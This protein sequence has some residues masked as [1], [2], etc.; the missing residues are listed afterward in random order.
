MYFLNRIR[1]LLVRNISW[2]D[3]L[4]C[5]HSWSPSSWVWKWAL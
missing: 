2:S 3:I 1:W 4:L 5:Y